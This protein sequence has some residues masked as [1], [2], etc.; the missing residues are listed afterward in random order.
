MLHCAS[1]DQSADI[2]QMG[3]DHYVCFLDV[4]AFIV[5]NHV[6]ESSIMID[7][8]GGFPSFYDAIFETELVIVH[9]ES[10]SAMH[11]T[12]TVLVSNPFA[13]E[14]LETS[15]LLH[16]S[17]VIEKWSVLHANEHLPICILLDNL[18]LLDVSL[19]QDVFQSGFSQDVE[20]VFL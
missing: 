2:L 11:N 5:R 17:K 14:Y 3:L 6:Q 10:R 12:S 15:L 1:L 8:N 7:G 18:V 16:F 13:T 19:L 9:S 4:H 20:F